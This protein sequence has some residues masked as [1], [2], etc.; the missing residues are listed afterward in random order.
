V[1]RSF[2]SRSNASTPS[3]ILG[4]PLGIPMALWRVLLAAITLVLVIIPSAPASIGAAQR[5]TQWAMVA[6]AVLGAACFAA[7]RGLYAS[8]PTTTNDGTGTRA[9]ANADAVATASSRPAA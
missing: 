7:P 1:W 5:S 2:A 8:P 3:G 6:C 9:G 4:R